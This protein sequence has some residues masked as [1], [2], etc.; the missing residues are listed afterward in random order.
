MPGVANASVVRSVPAVANAMLDAHAAIALVL[1]GGTHGK[2]GATRRTPENARV[3]ESR[4]Q[5]VREGALLALPTA[6]SC[7][8]VHDW[9]LTVQKRAWPASSLADSVTRQ[10][11]LRLS[12]SFNRPPRAP[13][14]SRGRR[15]EPRTP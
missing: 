1:M 15:S 14:P 13:N 12:A 9:I 11:L 8:H 2:F 5:E 3:A 7:R 10:L 4:A 6:I